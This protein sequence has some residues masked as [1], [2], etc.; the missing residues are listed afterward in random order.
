MILRRYYHR[1]VRHHQRFHIA[2]FLTIIA[3][4]WIV[5]PPVTRFF[6]TVG[7][8]DPKVYEPKDAERGMWLANRPLSL[9]GISW[10]T[11]L[12]VALFIFAG[13]AWLAVAPGMQRPGRSSR[14]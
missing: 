13:L 12:K 2:V 14:R 11:L 7:S 6:E 10:D 1:H 9:E 4:A 5:V 8:Y 3:V